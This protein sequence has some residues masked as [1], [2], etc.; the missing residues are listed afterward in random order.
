MITGSCLCGA[1]SYVVRG[2]L[3]PVI[4]CHCVQCRRSTGNFVA[5]TACRR[6]ALAFFEDRGLRWY[7]S[8]ARARRGF[9]AECGSSL[10]WE[11]FEGAEDIDHIS[12]MAGTLDP[13]TGLETRAHI[14]VDFA[15]DYYLIADGA[16]QFPASGH[17]VPYAE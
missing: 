15:G 5:A 3:R 13:P 9:C 16:P 17:G 6:D 11:R 12:I 2:P 10:F 7:R 8:S 14:F 4:A 1:V